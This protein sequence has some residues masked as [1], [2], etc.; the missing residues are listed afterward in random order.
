MVSLLGN[1]LPKFTKEESEII[2]GSY[3]FLGVN[4]YSTYY[5]QSIPQT[6]INM[7][8]YTDMQANVTRKYLWKIFTKISHYKIFSIAF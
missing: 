8:Y 4:Y 3:D 2:K 5:A 6:N 1:R 7:T